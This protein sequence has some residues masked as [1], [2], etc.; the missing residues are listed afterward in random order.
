VGALCWYLAHAIGGSVGVGVVFVVLVAVAAAMYLHSRKN[1]ISHTNV[2]E[3][4]DGG[5][6]PQPKAA[7]RATADSSV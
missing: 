1:P 2:N 6:V 5:L 7:S 3:E 4:W